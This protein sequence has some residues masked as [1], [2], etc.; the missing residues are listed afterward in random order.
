MCL[1]LQ[2]LF[3]FPYLRKLLQKL[4]VQKKCPWMRGFVCK[5]GPSVA[6]TKVRSLAFW[7]K[8]ASHPLKVTAKNTV[9]WHLE[10]KSKLSICLCSV[11]INSFNFQTFVESNKCQ[12]L[13]LDADDTPTTVRTSLPLRCSQPTWITM[14]DSYRP[15]NNLE[16]DTHT[17]TPLP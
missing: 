13:V 16:S 2:C 6:P 17:H 3:K 8:S 11:F 1:L 4:I 5:W 7:W 12:A 10:N 9:S 14:P 15:L